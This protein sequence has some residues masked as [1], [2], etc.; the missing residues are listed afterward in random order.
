MT[1]ASL[2]HAERGLLFSEM[3]LLVRK[4][5]EYLLRSAEGSWELAESESPGSSRYSK[6]RW[7]AWT[8]GKKA[9][10][11]MLAHTVDE[12]TNLLWPSLGE[13]RLEPAFRDL[14]D[15]HWFKTAWF[16][17]DR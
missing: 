5:R 9:L 16:G 1:L 6:A 12:Q 4:D 13:A 15:Q 2:I 11:P 14:I 8:E 3:S 7:A 10:I 17:Y